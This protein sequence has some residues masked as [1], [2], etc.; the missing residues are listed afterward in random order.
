MFENTYNDRV[1]DLCEVFMSLLDLLHNNCQTT[2]KDIYRTPGSFQE[3]LTKPVFQDTEVA[4]CRYFPGSVDD[5][6]DSSSM[7]ALGDRTSSPKVCLGGNHY[8]NQNLFQLTTNAVWHLARPTAEIAP[9]EYVEMNIHCVND[10]GEEAVNTIY[11]LSYSSGSVDITGFISVDTTVETNV[12]SRADVVLGL[13]FHQDGATTY[14]VGD[15]LCYLREAALN[16]FVI[17]SYGMNE[18]SAGIDI[19]AEDEVANGMVEISEAEYS[20]GALTVL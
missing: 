3:Y 5:E 6:I 19:P 12:I 4:V 9:H 16:E 1:V 15:A 8:E 17:T 10:N 2:I 14:A 18:I 13:Q 7:F 20:D 11:G